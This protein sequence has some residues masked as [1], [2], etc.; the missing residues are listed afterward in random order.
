[1]STDVIEP[2]NSYLRWN[3]VIASHFFKPEMEGQTVYLYLT[4]EVISELAGSIG[5]EKESF[6]EV[7]KE[8]PEWT[9]R[10]GLC[11]KALQSFQN[12]RFRKLEYPPYIAFLAL[13]VLAAETEGD[14]SPN[15]YY[16]RLRKLLGD[17]GDG[18]LPSFQLML[19]L[20]EDLET[21][22]A[23]DKQGDLGV[24]QARSLGGHIH[25]GFPIAQA[26]LTE[27][28][29]K[30]LPRIFYEAELDPTSLIPTDEIL[31]ALRTKGTGYL[32]PRTLRRLDS[33]S[34]TDM[35]SALID[36]ISQE[37]S[38]WDGEI[39]ETMPGK[40]SKQSFAGLRICMTVDFAAKKIQ[41]I[42]RCKLNREYPEEGLNLTSS[43]Y[44]GTIKTEESVEGW[45]SP[46]RDRETNLIVD[47]ANFDWISGLTLRDQTLG[48]RVK[49]P[50]MPVR[51]FADG[52]SEGLP[53]LVEI[54]ALPK[55]QPF[56]L[57]YHEG[58]WPQISEW[59]THEC[60]GF[61]E[62]PI[63]QGMPSM[64]K[65][66]QVTE[67]ISDVSIRDRLPF[68]SFLSTSSLRLRF[69]GGIRFGRGNNFFSF[70]PPD[71]QI[72]G[73]WPSVK[74]YCNDIQLSPDSNGITFKLPN[75][76]PVES[77]IAIEAKDGDKI[78]TRVNLF[79]TGEF[80]WN[81]QSPT[82][83]LSKFGIPLDDKGGEASVAGAN[84]QGQSLEITNLESLLLFDTL[85]AEL[86]NG[87]VFLIGQKPGQVTEWTGGDSTLGW[88]PIWAVVSGKHGKR[89][90]FCRQDIENARP[91]TDCFGTPK[92]IKAWREII[93]HWRKRIVPPNL[94]QLR[95]LWKQYQEVGRDV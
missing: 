88:Q 92:S 35:S 58:I 34:D 36:I 49:L 42:F 32:Q 19:Q 63:S 81:V 45:S 52:E 33:S 95:S 17:S 6:I 51:L 76:L 54:H 77:K 25:I 2:A 62:R 13:F 84:V 44:P 47:A 9:T 16:P 59:A 91:L 89:V 20:W 38:D 22:T 67:A 12:W 70:A 68:L 41:S 29:H 85:N 8:G 74:V 71:I 83:S 73:G 86:H 60:N 5:V 43:R 3:D 79:L 10:S 48:L 78:L 50:G 30:N 7:V 80:S 18:M 87:S 26:I 24:F 23:S 14:F 66:A 37:L 57:V 56:Y 93:W 1:M 53:G 72:E 27:E 11:Q 46:L 4:Q 40:P 69:V 64:W 90:I 15:A 61:S 28:E 94:R 82:V 75:G 65:L 55:G 39:P 31:R 21:W